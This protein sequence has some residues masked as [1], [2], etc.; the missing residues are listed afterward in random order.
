MQLNYELIDFK[1]FNPNNL[2]DINDLQFQTLGKNAKKLDWSQINY[3]QLNAGSLER[4]DWTSVDYKKALTSN[5]FSLDVVD[6][7]E[8]MENSVSAKS[9]HKAFDSADRTALVLEASVD[10]LTGLSTLL[11]SQGSQKRTYFI[12][13][14]D[15]IGTLALEA[16]TSSDDK[17]DA[18]GLEAVFGGSGN[19]VLTGMPTKN[20]SFVLASFL[21]G[22]AGDDRYVVKRGAFSFVAD[23]GGGSDTLD[24]SAFKASATYL[25]DVNNQFKLIF[26]GVTTALVCDSS[27]IEQVV[28]DRALH[29]V[30][31]LELAALHDGRY[32]GATTFEELTE[33]GFLDPS[34]GGLGVTGPEI[35]AAVSSFARNSGLVL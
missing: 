25:M 8:L 3:G 13:R 31:A 24:L 29:S 26:D 15:K 6:F 16:G 35:D 20:G 10:S 2:A 21:E 18:K 33:S 30:D 7:A 34:F 19:D 12:D 9:F 28:F 1:K 22:G 23:F 5:T 11:A 27:Q 4:I 14:P 32:L 17:L